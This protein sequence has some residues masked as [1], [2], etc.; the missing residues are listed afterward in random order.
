MHSHVWYWYCC[1]RDGPDWNVLRL[2]NMDDW[3]DE[4]PEVVA[5]SAGVAAAHSV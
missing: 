1:L 3:I 5:G 2:H 4:K